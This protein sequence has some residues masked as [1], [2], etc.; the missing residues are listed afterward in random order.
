MLSGQA[1]LRTKVIERAW[2]DPEFK[3]QLLSDPKSALKAVLGIS[4]PENIEI[5]AV[6]EK[7]NQLYLVIPPNPAKVLA[8]KSAPMDTW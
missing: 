1:L 3:Q 7:E 5:K 4:I 8:A 2:V 6:D